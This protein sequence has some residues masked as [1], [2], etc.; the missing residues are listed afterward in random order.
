MP[1]G[2]LVQQWTDRNQD[3]K[4]LCGRN[5]TQVKVN[6]K[7]NTFL[8][9]NHTYFS[10][11]LAPY[12]LWRKLGTLWKLNSLQIWMCWYIHIALK[13]FFFIPLAHEFNIQSLKNDIRRL[14][15]RRVQ[16]CKENLFGMKD[17]EQCLKCDL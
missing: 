10:T 16:T 6:S 12:I 8:I 4:M 2:W 15:E 11:V 5:C 9:E 17:T 7:L 1:L 3:I 14:E 13:S